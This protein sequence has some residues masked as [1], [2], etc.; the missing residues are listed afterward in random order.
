M[1]THKW[2]DKQIEEL[3]ELFHNEPCLWNNML[4]TYR[5]IDQRHADLRQI[6]V[7]LDGGHIRIFYFK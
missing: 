2:N 5:D 7:A 4:P 1:A 6:S 3:T